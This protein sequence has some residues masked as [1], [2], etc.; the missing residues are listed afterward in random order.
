[1]KL[2]RPTAITDASLTSTNVPEN[3]YPVYSAATTYFTGNRVIVIATHKIYE[4][5]Q[6]SNT[7]KYPPNY[8][9]GTPT[10]WMEVG[11]TNAWA[12]FDE[13]V[14]TQT[15]NPDTIQTVLQPGRINTLGFLQ[16]DCDSI[17]INME[18]DST[19]VYSRTISAVSSN[20]SNWYEYFFEPIVRKTDL[21][22]TDL[23]VFGTGVIT[24]M[25]DATGGTAKC[26]VCLAGY[27]KELGVMLWGVEVSIIDY[28][29]KETDEFG[30]FS[31]V[32]RGYS[33]RVSADLFVENSQINE[34][35]RLLAEYRATPVLWIGSEEFA[36]TIVYGFF[37]DFSVV[38]AD[39]AGSQCNIEIEGL[40]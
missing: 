39:P 9:S 21:V 7:N 12:M 11:P 28:S 24:I 27:Y 10:W 13:A 17:T 29:R 15:Q 26:G 23:P 5:L 3:D 31:V 14:A 18:V 30:A 19:V 16:I 37:R 2:V 6:D 36:A 34:T 4:S 1:M 35:T 32:Q 33:K 38:I 22:F 25:I 8:L 20:V 40:T